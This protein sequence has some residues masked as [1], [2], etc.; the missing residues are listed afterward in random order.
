MWVGCGGGQVAW[1][2]T[3]IHDLSVTGYSPATEH[4]SLSSDMIE[5]INHV[6]FLVC[7]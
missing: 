4:L 7:S 3:L 5:T 2:G 1:G 6:Y